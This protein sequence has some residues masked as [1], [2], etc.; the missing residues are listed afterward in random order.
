MSDS[1]RQS[2]H[3]R[4]EDMNDSSGKEELTEEEKQLQAQLLEVQKKMEEIKQKKRKVA[5]EEEEETRR[6]AVEVPRSP[7]PVRVLTVSSPSKMKSPKRLL[8]GIDKGKTGKDVSLGRKQGE[9]AV[10]PFHARLAEARDSDKKKEE[11]KKEAAKNRKTSFH[12]KPNSLET[13]SSKEPTYPTPCNEI[14]PYSRQVIMVRYLSDGEVKENLQGCYVY[15][16]RQLLKLIVPPKYEQP[17]VDTFVVMGIVAYNTG[18]RE[19]IHKKKYCMLTLTDLKWQM[20]VFLF[21]KAFERYWKV[22]PGTVVALLCPDILKP[23]NPDT[24]KFSLKLDSDY[25]VLLEIGKSK[26]LGYCQSRKKNGELCKHWLDNR[27]SEVCE[28]HVDMAVQRTM[29]RRTEFGSTT[30]VM[31]EPRARREKRLRGQGFQ[32]YYAGEKYSAVPNLAIGLYDAEDAVQQERDR[33]E[34]YKRQQAK[35]ERERE[36]LQR[37]TMKRSSLPDAS[38]SSVS[39]SSMKN[40]NNNNKNDTVSYTPALTLGHQY[41]N[42]Q[43]RNSTSASSSEMSQL[44]GIHGSSTSVVGRHH[45]LVSGGP[46]D[47]GKSKQQKDWKDLLVKPNATK[48]AVTPDPFSSEDKWKSEQEGRKTT[49]WNLPKEKRDPK[50]PEQGNS[51]ASSLSHG[52]T[53]AQRIFSPR[54]L[55]RIGF[56]P[57]LRN[58]NSCPGGKDSKGQNSSVRTLDLKNTKFRYEFTESDEEDDLEIVA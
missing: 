24:G 50:Q 8:L 14:E 33:K 4:M 23:K 1:N 22:Q 29:S 35:A 31:H 56:D 16:I 11:R 32:G 34:R 36:I 52:T 9:P 10:K 3:S 2:I 42:L 51:N 39:H 44:S 21:G 53:M 30:T 41:L 15:L 12:R 13:N 18:T 45:Q 5:T 17:D 19:T 48:T 37:L 46:D 28:F 26:H 25:D 49:A 58:S 40:N 7:E 6:A 38:S 57:T 20:E 55:R 47:K 27:L 43:A 54:S